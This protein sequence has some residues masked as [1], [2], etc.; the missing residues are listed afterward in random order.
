MQAGGR[1]KRRCIAA[2]LQSLACQTMHL[3]CMMAECAR[4]EGA[5][6]T[7]RMGRTD[8]DCR[9]PGPNGG[10]AGSAARQGGGGAAA[11]QLLQTHPLTSSNSCRPPAP[12]S[13]S[14]TAQ[15]SLR[16]TPKGAHRNQHAVP[17]PPPSSHRGRCQG[18]GV[19]LSR[20]PTE[21]RACTRSLL[22]RFGVRA[23]ER[24]LR[25]SGRH[26]LPAGGTAWGGVD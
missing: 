1:Q 10:D 14:D 16:R 2:H 5:S 17:A 12:L 26:Q 18:A 21:R 3:P 9:R 22:Q 13:A 11:Q 4:R 19:A 23:S 15:R 8:G 6:K 7:A 20:V 25:F 24:Q